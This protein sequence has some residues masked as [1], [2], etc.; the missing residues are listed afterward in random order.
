MQVLYFFIEFLKKN[1]DN[2]PTMHKAACLYFNVDGLTPYCR[3]FR[4]LVE[5]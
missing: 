3:M 5:Y 2:L 4:T 1:G